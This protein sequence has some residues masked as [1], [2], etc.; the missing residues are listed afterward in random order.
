LDAGEAGDRHPH[1]PPHEAVHNADFRVPRGHHADSDGVLEGANGTVGLE[2][3]NP[4][5]V[6]GESKKNCVADARG[7][8]W[9]R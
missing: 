5:K 8:E 1:R 9:N 3:Q 4:G 6:Q 7:M 2:T